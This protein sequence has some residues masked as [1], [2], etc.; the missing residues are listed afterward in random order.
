LFTPAPP[1]RGQQLSVYLPA[2]ALEFLRPWA[3]GRQRSSRLAAI[4][5][6]YDAVADQRPQL[7]K[8]EWGIVVQLLGSLATM[9][10]VGALWAEVL[11][12]ARE[13]RTLPGVDAEALARKL[14]Q[15]TTAEQ[16]AVLEV[17][18]RVALAAGPL[19]A[20]LA[21]AGIGDRS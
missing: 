20:R 2:H 13:G 17:A 4:V 7:S 16:I 3:A 6:R 9:R 10:Q 15:L 1:P 12:R 11:D 19:R 14:R 8:A 18:D 21:R 5:E